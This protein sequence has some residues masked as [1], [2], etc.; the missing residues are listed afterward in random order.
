MAVTLV[1]FF[2]WTD[3][4]NRATSNWSIVIADWESLRWQWELSHA[5][6]AILTFVVLCCATL[7]TQRSA[8]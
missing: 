6:N 5:A 3:P 7:S 1:I 8:D 2:T 4:A